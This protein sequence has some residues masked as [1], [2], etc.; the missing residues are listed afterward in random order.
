MEKLLKLIGIIGASTITL[1]GSYQILTSGVNITIKNTDSVPLE[2]VA[3]W[4]DGKTF[5]LGQIEPGKAKTVRL[6]P[7]QETEIYVAHGASDVPPKMLKVGE[8]LEPGYQGNMLVEAN[9]EK[10]SLINNVV[11]H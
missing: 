7:T 2:N 6:N 9:R 10:S 11:W 8:A 1:A 5:E 4:L 3:I